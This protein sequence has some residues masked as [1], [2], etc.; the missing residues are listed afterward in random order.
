MDM[1]LEKTQFV[2]RWTIPPKTYFYGTSK[3]IV[4]LTTPGLCTIE[5]A[6]AL[7][8]LLRTDVN[9]ESSWS[10]L[11]VSLQFNGY[12]SKRLTTL[13]RGRILRRVKGKDRS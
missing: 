12:T 4:N 13:F 3:V 11:E 5:Q 7:R 10:L 1:A 9:V 6:P 2:L 8:G